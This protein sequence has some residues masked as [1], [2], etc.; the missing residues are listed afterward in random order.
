MDREAESI[1]GDGAIEEDC[2][3]FLPLSGS[4][5]PNIRLYGPIYERKLR[6]YL[7]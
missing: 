7:E 3:I 4:T 5:D 2:A 1:S 6:S